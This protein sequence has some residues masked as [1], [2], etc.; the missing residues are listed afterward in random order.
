MQRRNAGIGQHSECFAWICGHRT[1]D[2]HRLS[3][4]CEFFSAHC[5]PTT[6]ENKLEICLFCRTREHTGWNRIENRV[7]K[8][9]FAGGNIYYDFDAE[10]HQISGRRQCVW[11]S[12]AI[13]TK[14]YGHDFMERRFSA[15]RWIPA[16]FGGRTGAR[17]R[18]NILQCKANSRH[19]KKAKPFSWIRCGL[20]N[21]HHMFGN[22][23]KCMWMWRS[24]P[25]IS[26]YI[27]YTQNITIQPRA[28]SLSLFS[29][30][31]MI[32]VTAAGTTAP[33][34]VKIGERC[35]FTGHQAYIQGLY[36]W[37]IHSNVACE[38][39]NLRLRTE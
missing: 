10:Y 29:V 31:W 14:R 11:L 22:D 2:V 27:I 37:C 26:T 9:A 30:G 7:Y 1:C 35:F 36:L 8:W 39:N 23:G 18:R 16:H 20:R 21:V 15:Y 13:H 34:T 17:R 28:F 24:A 19:A 25:A 4:K 5:S 32:A 6:T 38:T 33:N 3:N 12:F